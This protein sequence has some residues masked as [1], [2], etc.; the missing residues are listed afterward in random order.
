VTTLSTE[1]STLNSAAADSDSFGSDDN[2]D[3]TLS[4]RPILFPDNPILNGLDA[5]L[6]KENETLTN[7]VKRLRVENETLTQQVEELK[8]QLTKEKQRSETLMENLKVLKKKEAEETAALENMVQMVEK[9]LKLT[10]KRAVKA[11]S[12]VARLQKDLQSVTAQLTD[13]GRQKIE[14][15]F[16]SQFALIQDQSQVAAEKM[17][18]AATKAEKSLREIFGN[19]ED[20]KMA[21][22]LMYSVAHAASVAQCRPGNLDDSS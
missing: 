22:N 11:E 1:Q 3:I 21:S 17:V 8:E 6:S 15:T 18:S 2:E 20:L 13:S 16:K 10:T 9:N 14:E 12:E 19:V 7:D 4:K 5:G